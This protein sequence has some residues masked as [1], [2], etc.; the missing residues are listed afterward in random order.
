MSAA[1]WHFANLSREQQADAIRRLAILGHS[2]A[3][4]AQ[5]T[6]LSVDQIRRALAE[7]KDMS[8]GTA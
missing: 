4:I 7:H 6:G 3:T 2:E 5:A 8:K 1:L